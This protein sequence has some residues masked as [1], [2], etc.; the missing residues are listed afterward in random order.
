MYI[1]VCLFLS[2]LVVAVMGGGEQPKKKEL[3]GCDLTDRRPQTGSSSCLFYACQ[4]NCA[5]TKSHW[6]FN[7]FYRLC[8]KSDKSHCGVGANNFRTCEE[9]RNKCN[10]SMCAE[11]MTT[12]DP[13]AAIFMPIG[14]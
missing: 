13:N 9:C 8:F 7:W 12:P 10:V 4:R 3:K 11:A 1:K 6:Y 5:R 14:R 2:L